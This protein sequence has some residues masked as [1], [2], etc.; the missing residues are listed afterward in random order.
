VYFLGFLR[1]SKWGE[2]QKLYAAQRMG[3]SGTIATMKGRSLLS[4]L[5]DRKGES[6][7]KV[8]ELIEKKKLYACRTRPHGE[9]AIPV[10]EEG[11][12]C[13]S[14]MGCGELL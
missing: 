6:R 12:T 10:A 8:C 14:C 11:G 13:T 2:S 5:R 9:S 4:D 3:K 1:K 7:V